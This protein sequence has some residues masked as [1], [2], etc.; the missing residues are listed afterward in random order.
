MYI[1]IY[2]NMYLRDSGGG[3]SEN[4]D[5]GSRLISDESRRGGKERKLAGVR[6]VK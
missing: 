6:K 1:Y 3:E 5:S 4:Q 2:S